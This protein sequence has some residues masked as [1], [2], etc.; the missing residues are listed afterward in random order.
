VLYWKW[1]RRFTTR[2]D[3]FIDDGIWRFR[4]KIADREISRN[5]EQVMLLNS[6]KSRLQYKTLAV[7]TWC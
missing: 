4:Q 7:S 2:N 3:D 5:E 1:K 6:L